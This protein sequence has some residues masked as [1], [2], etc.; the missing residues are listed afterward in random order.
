MAQDPAPFAMPDGRGDGS[1][2]ADPIRSVLSR[3]G[4]LIGGLGALSLPLLGA[5]SSSSDGSGGNTA[6]TS[7]GSSSAAV[8]PT[9]GQLRM[10]RPAT[11]TGEG[12]D[13]VSDLYTYEFLGA[14]YNRLVKVAKDGTL[15]PDL[16][17]E[18]EPSAD[19]LTWTFKLRDGVTWHDGKPFTSKDAKYTFQHMFDIKASQSAVL[20]PIMTP[21]DIQTPDDLT[22]VFK[23]TSAHAEFPTLLTNYSSYLI[24]DGSGD[25]IA[26]TG[27]G[28]GPFQLVSF[29]S[30]G[31]GEV[32]ANPNYFGGP[33]K[34]DS[35]EFTAIADAQARINALMSGQVDIISQTNLDYATQQVVKANPLLTTATVDNAVM[36]AMPMLPSMAPFDN[37]EVR[38]AFKTAYQPQDLLDLAVHGQG[39]I[40]NNNPVLSTDPYYLDYPL[41][42]DP[43]KAAAT[44][45]AAGVTEQDLYTSSFEAVYEPLALAYQASLAEAGIT[46]NVKTAPADSYYTETY[47]KKS[48]CLSYWYTGRPI[49]QL[50]NLVFRGPTSEAQWDDQ[51]FS[52]LLDSARKEPDQAKRKQLYQDAQKLAIDE[53]GEIVPFFGHRTTGLTT[54]VTN[55]TEYGFEFDYLNIGI[56]P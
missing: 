6:P 17:T 45:K 20:S 36:Y 32:K 1:P 40:A 28:T 53:S 50:L 51:Q 27:I 39:T 54:K 26:Q 2:G 13:P 25:T 37:L 42:P 47:A 21:A 56:Q 38:Q 55:Y 52:D 10:A 22:L 41:T 19:L 48:F 35:I 49:D 24:P 44:L 14:L 7:G 43:E 29:V 30:G 33:P 9:G 15:A 11:R 18:W 23:L 12:L 31:R 4:M 8:S 5:C 16:A 46:I 34:L 3:R